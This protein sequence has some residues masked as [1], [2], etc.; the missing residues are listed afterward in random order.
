MLVVH[1]AG[2][3]G[4]GELVSGTTVAVTTTTGTVGVAE[5]GH[6][7]VPMAMVLVVT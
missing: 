4:A 3:V 5:T 6:T 2:P 7:V 1:C